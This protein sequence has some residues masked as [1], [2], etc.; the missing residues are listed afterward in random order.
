MTNKLPRKLNFELSHGQAVWVLWH[1]FDGGPISPAFENYVKY[2]RRRGIP[3]GPDEIGK[4]RGVHVQYRYEHVMELAL[5]LVLRTQGVLKEDA[6]KLL[7]GVRGELRPLFVKAWK[8]RE[9]KIGEPIEVVIDG[10]KRQI[11]G[12]WLDLH[13]HY[14]NWN[15]MGLGPIKLLGPTQAAET[16]L[17]KG[18]QLMFRDPIRISDIAEKV[19]NLAPKVPE[20]KRGPS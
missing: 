20:I 18:R 19:A 10:E 8:L 17:A 5:A 3:F 13:L 14:V 16:M 1:L 2:L 4:G 6:V 12:L 7:S 11:H 9:S 15:L